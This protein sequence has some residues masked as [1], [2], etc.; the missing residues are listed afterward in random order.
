MIFL[1][2]DA[3]SLLLEAISRGWRL[4]DEELQ[5]I[6][7]HVAQVGYD[8]DARER[9]RGKLAG[10][11]WQGRTLRGRDMLPPARGTLFKTCS[12]TERMA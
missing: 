12:C 5:K 2:S 10:L 9:A 8:P 11:N 3:G 7:E 6:L 4:T 1:P